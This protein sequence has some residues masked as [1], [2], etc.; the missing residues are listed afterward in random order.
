MTDDQHSDTAEQR[1]FLAN[2]IEHAADPEHFNVARK[3]P[4]EVEYY[5]FSCGGHF[6]ANEVQSVKI[7]Y[8]NVGATDSGRS[9]TVAYECRGCRE[10][11]PV[12]NSPANRAVHRGY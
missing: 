5:C 4:G 3:G 10:K 8:K 9:R 6:P 1:A 11:D 12:F 2:L 7:T